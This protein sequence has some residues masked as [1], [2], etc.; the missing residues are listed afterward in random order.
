MFL[1]IQEKQN[2]HCYFDQEQ[3]TWVRLPLAWEIKS[4]TVKTLLEP[5][6]VNNHTAFLFFIGNST[7]MNK[8]MK[9]YSFTN[10]KYVYAT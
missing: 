9:L 6:E 1:L 8:A 4:E 7:V 3:G 5:I 10:S 2:V